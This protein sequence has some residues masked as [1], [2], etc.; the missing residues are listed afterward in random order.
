MTADERVPPIPPGLRPILLQAL[1]EALE[2]QYPGIIAIPLAPGETPPPGV[3]VI[4]AGPL[5]HR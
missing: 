1:A 4:P 2:D 3:R 5:G